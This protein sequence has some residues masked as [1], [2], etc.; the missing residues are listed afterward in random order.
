MPQDNGKSKIIQTYIDVFHAMHDDVIKETFQMSEK[1]AG[2]LFEVINT[3]ID[4]ILLF[5]DYDPKMVVH[6]IS[7][8]IFVYLC[9]AGNWIAY[10][11]LTGHYFDALRDIRFLFE[12]SLLAIHYDYFIDNKIYEKW[13]S[14]GTLSLKAEVVELAERLREKV[15]RSEGKEGSEG[16]KLMVR[17]DVKKYVGKSKLAE[18]EKKRYIELYCEILAQPELYWSLSRIIKEYSKEWEL[19]DLEDV[20]KS[21][22]GRLSLYTHFSTEFFK[23]ALERPEEIS[24]EFHN[25]ELLK[26]C[27]DLY[28]TTVDLFFS[29]LILS[30]P[31]MSSS[32]KEIAKRWEANLNIKLAITE[33]ILNTLEKA[34]SQ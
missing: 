7:G 16:L 12:G 27:C 30:F 20:L 34:S 15:R 13:G 14:L 2:I 8:V 31:K 19:G 33:R 23:L 10:E 11:I 3:W 18:E 26:I 22:W 29:T 25:E 28:I 4:S 32:L 9:K 21:A 17:K 24:V 5:K 6:K 1:E